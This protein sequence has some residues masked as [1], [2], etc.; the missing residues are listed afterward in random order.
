MVVGGGDGG[1]LSCHVA[2]WETFAVAKCRFSAFHVS[3]PWVLIVETG[4]RTAETPEG[5]TIVNGSIISWKF[6]IL[7]Y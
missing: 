2:N 6:P 7:V 3:V 1:G 5:T 4:T